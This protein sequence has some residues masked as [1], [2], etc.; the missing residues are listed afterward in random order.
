MSTAIES[1]SQKP[2]RRWPQFSLR[3]LMV[4]LL[5][6]GCGLGCLALATRNAELRD[7]NKKLGYSLDRCLAERDYLAQ[8]AHLLATMNHDSAK[9]Q[10]LFAFVRTIGPESLR[11]LIRDL[12]QGNNLV[13]YSFHSSY[14]LADGTYRPHLDRK[15]ALVLVDTISLNV[16]DIIM[17]EGYRSEGKTVILGVVQPWT[18]SWDQKDG[19]TIEYQILP[20]GFE[21]I[22]VGK[23]WRAK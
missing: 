11:C 8:G 5:F 7:S 14:E 21:R 2:R 19:T 20:T 15:S 18:A 13:V 1:V 17:H 10:E 6:V 9:H 22:N 23:R 16:I 3:T 4:F 12:E